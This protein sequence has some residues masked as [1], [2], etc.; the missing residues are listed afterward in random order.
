VYGGIRAIPA[1]LYMK[2]AIY[3]LHMHL[4]LTFFNQNYYSHIG[5]IKLNSPVR[6]I[7]PVK[8]ANDLYF[9]NGQIPQWFENDFASK[10]YKPLLTTRSS[11][12]TNQRMSNRN[13]DNKLATS[14]LCALVPSSK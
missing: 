12:N 11:V 9:Y 1:I 5:I 8:L 7:K 4:K 14:S 2:A 13:V 3:D 6:S 10:A